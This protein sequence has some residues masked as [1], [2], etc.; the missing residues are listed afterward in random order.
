[1]ATSV[2]EVSPSVIFCPSVATMSRFGHSVS[3]TVDRAFNEIPIGDA[4]D[5]ADLKR[6]CISLAPR[7]W[8]P[9]AWLMMTNFTVA[10]SRPSFFHPLEI[11]SSEL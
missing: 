1:V 10:G 11:A 7:T 4:H 9:W 6:S 5:D 8:S 2:T 3:G